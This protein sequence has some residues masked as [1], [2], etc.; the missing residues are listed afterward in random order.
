MFARFV[1]AALLTC[2]IAFPA[3]AADAPEKKDLKNQMKADLR[4]IKEI[5]DKTPGVEKKKTYAQMMV[6]GIFLMHLYDMDKVKPETMEKIA[7]KLTKAVDDDAL[8]PE[9]VAEWKKETKPLLGR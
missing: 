4:H 7:K 6:D 9:E 8:S 3:H 1:T 2:A 5:S